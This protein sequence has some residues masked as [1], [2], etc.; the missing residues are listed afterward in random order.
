M[1]YLFPKNFAGI[2]RLTRLTKID[3][4]GQL[5]LPIIK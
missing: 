2:D 5:L 3:R 4:K 1:K